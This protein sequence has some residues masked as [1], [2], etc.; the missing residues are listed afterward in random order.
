MAGE[1]KGQQELAATVAATVAASTAAS[2]ELLSG[3]VIAGRY[4][5]LGLLGAGGMGTVYRVRDRE[6]DE[7]VAL[8]TLQRGWIDAPGA[9]EQFR[10]EVKLARRVTHRN[11]ARTFDIGEGEDRSGPDGR[12]DKFLTMEYIDGPSLA[13]EIQDRGALGV[14]EALRVA[15]EIA[16][17]L[18][19]A[20]AAG[21][22]HRDLK[23]DNVLLARDG[24]VVVTDFGIA[25]TGAALAG[26]LGGTLIGTPAYMSP[27]QVEGAPLDARSDLYALGLVLFEMITGQRAFGGENAVAIAA[28]R[29]LEPAPDPA[30]VRPG[31]PGAITAVTRRLLARAREDRP[32]DAEAVLAMLAGID[33]SVATPPVAPPVVR[34]AGRSVAVYPLR[35]TGAAEDAWIAEG[36]TD[37]LQDGLCMIRGLRVKGRVT[38]VAGDDARAHG[39]RIGVDLVVD[40]SVRRQGEGVRVQLRMT[41]VHD[42]FQIWARRHDAGLGELLALGERIAE[43]LAQAAGAVDAVAAA[44]VRGGVDPRAIELYLRARGMPLTFTDANPAIELLDQALVLAPREPRI[45][46]A[47]AIAGARD[48]FRGGVAHDVAL[49]RARE[50]AERAVELAPELAEPW[51]ALAHV[52]N[53]GNDSPG[54]MRAIRRALIVGPSV[55]EGHEIAARMLGEADR[56]DEAMRLI[57]QA[58]WL[59]SH[60]Q[61]GRI[62]RVRMLGLRGDFE[63]VRRE[64]EILRGVSPTQHA[65]ISTRMSLWAG[66][67]MHDGEALAQELAAFPR[68]YAM[69]VRGILA[70]SGL[71]AAGRGAIEAILGQSPAGSRTKRFFCQLACE[72][73]AAVDDRAAAMAALAGSV[74]AG[75]E[76]L[77]WVDRCP[78][79][80]G[81]R[82][83]AGFGG[84][85]D[86]VRRRAAAIT[87]AWDDA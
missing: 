72:A 3:Q 41:G 71:S 15:G 40:G 33:G 34:T 85:R 59:A 30:T 52:R 36:L 68:T 87:A 9:L 80:A 69:I 67:V 4:E 55:A 65:I 12:A 70:G 42:G 10:S 25:S 76:D 5:I 79:I 13:R 23:P 32:A 28:A 78:V 35:F 17:A 83:E 16:E 53:H 39:L 27:E 82:A 31:L 20:H 38:P 64:L 54:A 73:Y 84:L 50:Q 86:E 2:T 62:E 46:A 44:P 14:G 47:R 11:V 26:S 19:A 8:K 24:R 43:E 61:F 60:L 49:A 45:L 48:V 7:V 75:L 56:L 18:R 29:L 21:V 77:A 66:R 1:P 57:D 22:I 63:G 6:L 51:I 81:V 58:L 74:A 37:D